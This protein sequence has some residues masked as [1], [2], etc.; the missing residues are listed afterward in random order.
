[1]S[2]LFYIAICPILFG[3]FPYIRTFPGN[4]PIYRGRRPT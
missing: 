4:Q 3:L 2:K 1:M